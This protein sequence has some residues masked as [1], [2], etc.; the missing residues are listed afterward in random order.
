[1]SFEPFRFRYQDSIASLKPLLLVGRAS[2]R[3]R[4]SHIRS[5]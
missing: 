2:Y 4:L 1:M 3:R 5:L